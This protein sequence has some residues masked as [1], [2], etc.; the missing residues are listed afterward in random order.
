MGA[1][2]EL[3]TDN[4]G[5]KLKTLDKATGNRKVEKQLNFPACTYLVFTTDRF[6]LPVGFDKF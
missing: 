5:L 1:N 3:F 6:G 2:L 4:E